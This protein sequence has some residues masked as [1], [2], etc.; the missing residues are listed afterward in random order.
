MVTVYVPA[1]KLFTVAL[2]DPKVSPND[3]KGGNETVVS[4]A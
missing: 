2:F 4:Q 3:A 1:N